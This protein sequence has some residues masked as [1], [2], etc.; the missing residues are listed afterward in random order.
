VAVALS[1]FNDEQTVV[2]PVGVVG[3]GFAF[4]VTLLVTES[5]QPL[6]LVATSFTAYVPTAA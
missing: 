5:L 1:A 6:L 3:D 4:T 2:A